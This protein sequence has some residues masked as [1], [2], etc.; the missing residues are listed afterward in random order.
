[1]PPR[2]LPDRPLPP[3]AYV[4]GRTPHPTRDA[5]GHLHG[6]A[7][8]STPAPDPLD[9]RASPSYLHG[10]DLYN[11]GYYWEA[12]EAWESLW[13]ACGRRGPTARFLQALIRLA[14][15]GFKVREGRPN[16][17]IRHAQ[18]AAAAFETL[19]RTT[20]PRFMGLALADL[21][22]DAAAIAAGDPAA[23]AAAAP[24][25]PVFARPLL[26]ID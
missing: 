8:A 3:Y 19:A 13:H 26:P 21:A 2:L 5:G 18:A 25:G 12:H 6:R 4:P 7:P 23:M 16:G 22:H 11:H 9:W 24:V 15:A 20:G 10:I 1:M 14:A 17:R